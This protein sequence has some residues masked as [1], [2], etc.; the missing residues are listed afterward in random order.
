MIRATFEM[1]P[2]QHASGRK[3]SASAINNFPKPT[4]DI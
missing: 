3:Y 2:S 4:I 1:I